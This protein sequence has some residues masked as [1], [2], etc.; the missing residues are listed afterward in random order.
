MEPPLRERLLRVHASAERSAHLV[1]QLLTLARS[2]PDAVPIRTQRIDLCAQARQ[3]VS[4]HVPR[5]LESWH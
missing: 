5:A 4:E 3:W 1:G 2:D